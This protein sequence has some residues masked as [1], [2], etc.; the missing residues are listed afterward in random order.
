[1]SFASLLQNDGGLWKNLYCNTL[2]VGSMLVGSVLQ[3]VPVGT[4]SKTTGSMTGTK[5]GPTRCLHGTFHPV[6]S[7]V[8]LLQ[9]STGFA[10]ATYVS[11]GEFQINFTDNFTY[12]PTVQATIIRPTNIF[13]DSTFAYASNITTSGCRIFIVTPGAA[14][15]NL[16]FGLTINGI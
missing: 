1:M 7:T 3:L 13:L 8:T 16:D 14:W 2:T 11:M 4:Q 6:P 9:G 12:P 5:T 15:R 10:S